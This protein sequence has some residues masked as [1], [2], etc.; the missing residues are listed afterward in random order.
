MVVLLWSTGALAAG[1]ALD[2]LFGDPR[3][4]PHMVRLMGQLIAALEK[5]LR[6][7]LP[8]TAEGE[9]FG[10]AVLVT[11]LTLACLSIPLGVLLLCYRLFAPLGFVIESLLC[12][13]V[14]AAKSL[15]SESMGVR[16]ALERGDIEAA[17]REVS[18][19]VG[20]DT[21]SL[22][23]P[24]IIRAA[25]ETV[26]EN[27]SDG[28]TAPMLFTMLGG[29]PAGC[30]YKAVST[31]DSMVGYKNDEY[32]NFGRAAARLDDIFN[33]IPSRLSALFM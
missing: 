27:T 22:D 28:V 10:G 31:M 3:S 1:F 20:R 30:L 18:M 19:I 32:I 33:H 23:G 5:R 7:T 2:L 12:W 21:A 15:K 29:A 26:A 9:L 6:K 13:Q 24:G 11:C 8:A 17:R 14:L 25:V 16:S 4:F